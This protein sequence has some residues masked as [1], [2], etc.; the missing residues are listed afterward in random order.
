MYIS[1]ACCVLLGR[2]SAKGR[3]LVQRNSAECGE[4]VCVCVCVSV[5]VSSRPQKMR[6]SP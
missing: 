6:P 3:S 4:S 5:C 2:F 1:C